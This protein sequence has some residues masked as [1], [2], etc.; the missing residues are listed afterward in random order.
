MLR[1]ATCLLV[2]GGL[3]FFV[4]A[5]TSSFRDEKKHPAEEKGIK[6][7]DTEVE[8]MI[9]FTNKSG[10]TVKVY[11]LDY[12]G[13]RVHYQTLEDKES[14]D[15]HTYLGHPWLITDEKENAL[16]IYYPDAQPRTV[17]ITPAEK[18]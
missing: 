4:A 11:W 18:K 6:S 13:G 1:I 14:H 5:S 15:Q 16:Y 3:S 10:K 7:A 8:T 2:L 17:E 12:D 9:T